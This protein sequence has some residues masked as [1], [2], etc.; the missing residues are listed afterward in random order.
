MRWTEVKSK[1][2]NGSGSIDSCSR[3]LQT[4]GNCPVF[5]FIDDCNFSK[6]SSRTRR[7]CWNSVLINVGVIRSGDPRGPFPHRNPADSN[8]DASTITILCTFCNRCYLRCL[9]K[10]YTTAIPVFA[11]T[12]AGG[13]AVA[14]NYQP[15]HGL[16]HPQITCLEGVWQARKLMLISWCQRIRSFTLDKCRLPICP[17]DYML[18]VTL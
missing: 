6:S 11:V 5:C 18:L 12:S 17:D 13:T 7:N 9:L 15:K 3:I 4:C 1:L 10:S 14:A 16:M 2:V 8:L